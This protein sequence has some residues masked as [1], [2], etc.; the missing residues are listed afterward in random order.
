MEVW[1]R[2]A[3][4]NPARHDNEEHD[5]SKSNRE[6]KATIAAQVAELAEGTDLAWLA[7]AHTKA[8]LA[9]LRDVLLAAEPEEGELTQ[10]QVMSRK[11]RE[12]RQRYEVTVA[13][14]GNASADNADVIAQA[15]RGLEP[16]Q[17]VA[18][19]E[20]ILGMTEGELWARYERL[21][22]GQQ[23]M[24]AGNRIRGA[25]KRGD[26]VADEVIAQLH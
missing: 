14:S 11:L 8:Q 17:V 3:S 7:K 25:I 26:V 20:R 19:A 12:A 1:S 6:T 16:R 13:A 23:R 21:N 4:R 22:P 5:M 10:A 15:L 2:G 9:D 24:N 18:A